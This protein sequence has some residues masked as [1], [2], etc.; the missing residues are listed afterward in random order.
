MPKTLFERANDLMQKR[1]G[2]D[3]QSREIEC[4]AD[5]MEETLH[6]FIYGTSGEENVTRKSYPEYVSDRLKDSR[7]WGE[8][9]DKES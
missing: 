6:M 9:D 7:E 4:L 1:H 3:I 8:L 2:E 5:A